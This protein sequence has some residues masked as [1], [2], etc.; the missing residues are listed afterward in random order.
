MKESSRWKD[1]KA[2]E[3]YILSIPKFT[4]KNNREDTKDFY[5]Y[6]RRPGRD[7]LIF[8]V[9]GTNGKGS[10]CSY[11]NS[12]LLEEGIS[13]GMFTSP[14]LV[15]MRERIQYQ[16]ELIGE[17]AFVECFHQLMEQLNGFQER[18][19]QY[20]PTFFELLFFMAM[21]YFEEKNPKVIILETGLGGRLDATNIVEGEKVCVITKIGMDHM[22]YLGNTVEAIAREKAGIIQPGNKVIYSANRREIAEVIEKK[23][24][25]AGALCK[26]VTK[27][28]NPVL[29][30]VDKT[31]DFSF[32]SR[33]YGYIPIR[34]R[35]VA[36]YQIEN[37]ALALTALEES[38][39]KISES[40]MK[41]GMARSVWPARM[42]EILPGV[43][44]DGAHNEDGIEAFLTT[45]LKDECKKERWILFSV[46]ADKEFLKM[47]EMLLSSGLFHHVYATCLKNIRGVK[48]Q[49]L[50]MIFSGEKVKIIESTKECLQEI[51]SQKKEGDLVYITGSLYLA[52][53]VKEMLEG[54]ENPV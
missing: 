43:Y 42:E 1:I 17:E 39:L 20:H 46:V 50:E 38:G 4:T 33:Y 28:E 52:G 14:H 5:E 47:K 34:I 48:K 35:T 19:P 40:G 25:K 22:E 24:G 21:L 16:G 9:A 23:A 18:K 8:H 49:Q 7:S 2:I 29:S 41:R 15:S 12:V 3:E 6:L 10:V 54:L 27:P 45:V 30:F 37:A 36:E 13:A 26:F 32:S 53:E 44:L 51:L 31:I 11:L